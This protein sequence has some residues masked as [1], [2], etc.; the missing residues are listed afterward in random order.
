MYKHIVYIL[1]IF[2][3]CSCQTNN[4]Q[5]KTPKPEKV[6]RITY[7]IESNDWYKKQSALWKEEIDKNPSIEEAWYNY[8]NANRY[9]RFEEIGAP[10]RKAK[11]AKIIEDMGKAIP[12]TY[13][14]HLLKFWNSY[15]CREMTDAEKAYAINPD[16]PD[17]YY[18]FLSKAMI[19][20]EDKL[21]KEF[22]G[23]LY[24]SRD[25]APW[26]YNYCY[27]M[28]MSV[29]ENGILFTNG[30]NDTYP[31]L[32]LQQVKGIRTDVQIINTS[33][34]LD[35]DYFE[36][37]LV[38]KGYKLD[39]NDIKKGL[40]KSNFRVEFVHK[41]I[42][43]MLKEYPKQ[44]LYFAA[45]IYGA[46]MKPF[47][48]DLYLTGLAFKHSNERTDNIALVKNNLEN[49]FRLDYLEMGIYNDLFPGK[50]LEA[51][52]NL[53]YVSAILILGDHYKAGGDDQKAEY[54]KN[55]ALKLALRAGKDEMVREIENKL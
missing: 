5:A 41:F 13:T 30:D 31:P 49:K 47:K 12:G 36:N 33:L 8:Y 44:P 25:I 19:F 6:Y 38:K 43:L 54:W 29:E 51:Y 20:G 22:S 48:P 3:F 37:N 1:I 53:N 4:S 9:A 27:N 50:K 42:S 18:A 40:N 23:K 2:F 34:I 17:I 15:N 32:I 7:E 55:L 10:E 11:L 14:Y 46:Q 21:M 28:L 52:T 16:R 45:T 35:K 39:Y 24:N 26:L